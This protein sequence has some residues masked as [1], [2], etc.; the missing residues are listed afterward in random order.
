MMDTMRISAALRGCDAIYMTG[1]QPATRQMHRTLTAVCVVYAA[2]GR[3]HVAAHAPAP[4]PSEGAVCGPHAEISQPPP[5]PRVD[6]SPAPAAV[7][8]TVMSD[9]EFGRGCRAPLVCSRELRCV[10]PFQ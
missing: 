3:R 10:S 1:P 8:V 5:P 4:I 6:S 2:S 9:H 7:P